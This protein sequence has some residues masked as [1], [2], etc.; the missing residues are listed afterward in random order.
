MDEV[1]R[2]PL[3]GFARATATAREPPVRPDAGV[4]RPAV[5]GARTGARPHGSLGSARHPAEAKKPA[6]TQPVNQRMTRS[7]GTRPS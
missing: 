1:A 6:D 3:A 5:H 2:A 4:P 7:G